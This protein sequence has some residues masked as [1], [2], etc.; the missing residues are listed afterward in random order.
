M[1]SLH[2][3]IF[4][5]FARL[6]KTMEMNCPRLRRRRRSLEPSLAA[7]I[8]ASGR[9]RG[10]SVEIKRGGAAA[11]CRR[12]PSYSGQAYLLRRRRGEK[13]LLLLFLLAYTDSTRRLPPRRRPALQNQI[14]QSKILAK[15]PWK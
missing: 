5:F 10:C 6:L 2:F 14:Y 1:N 9:R 12:S 7:V 15:I 3:F 11:P 8:R 4:L 13:L